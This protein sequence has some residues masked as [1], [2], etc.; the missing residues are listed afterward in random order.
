[1]KRT[2]FAL[3]LSALALCALPALAQEA[4]CTLAGGTPVAEAE[5]MNALV[6]AAKFDDLATALA[7]TIGGLAPTAFD[8]VKGAY[9]QAF[10]SCTTVVQRQDV[11]GLSQHVVV[12]EGANPLFVYWAVANFGGKTGVISF[13]MDS[14]LG[15]VLKM[16]N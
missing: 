6:K 12:F 7:A 4:A 16:L 14:T 11:G 8:G 5:A 3:A 10:D 2:A 13:N 1:M 9:P 15:P